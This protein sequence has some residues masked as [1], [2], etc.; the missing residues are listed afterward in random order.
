MKKHEPRLTLY[1]ERSNFAFVAECILA[2]TLF[3]YPVYTIIQATTRE[4]PRAGNE[5]RLV[6]LAYNQIH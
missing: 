4:L 1:A 6:E 3:V 2:A 5:N